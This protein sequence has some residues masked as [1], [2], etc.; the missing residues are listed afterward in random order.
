[1]KN[2][3]IINREQ[4]GYHIDNY[5]YCYYMKG[6]YNI[7]YICFD[8][9][10][11]KIEINGVD[12]FYISNKKNKIIRY[13]RFLKYCIYNLLKCNSIVFIKYFQGSSVLKLFFPK[14]VFVLDIRSASVNQSIIIRFLYDS[15]LKIETSMFKNITVISDGLRNRLAL[16]QV[17]TK[18]I[19]LGAIE[20]S[21][22][23]KNYDHIRLL[24]VG[25]F[26]NRNIEETIYGFNSFIMKYGKK[27]DYTIIGISPKD[28]QE[29]LKCLV[30]NL[31]LEKY[32]N[33]TGYVPQ[34]KLRHYFDKCNV[35][36]SFIPITDYFNFQP[37]TKTYEYLMSGLP[38]IA[39]RTEENMQIITEENGVLIDDNRNS[40]EEG[41]YRIFENKEQFD[42]FKIR[43]S[44]KKYNWKYIVND[45]LI[46]YINEL[47]YNS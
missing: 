9:G 3:I 12:V 17:K 44:V 24:Y 19:P 29:K 34:Y 45:N 25:T 6:T 40:F 21:N 1:M 30:K 11:E 33:F 20:I 36:V 41:I 43:N 7:K 31:N 8:Y 23:P 39:T 15:I 5:Y 35:G 10:K 13:L 18:K 38:T 2:I 22:K 37:P 4:F 26:Y 14:I 28:E 27:I 47:Y 32:I 42:D 16:N 46:P